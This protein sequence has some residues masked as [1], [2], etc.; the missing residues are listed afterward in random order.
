MVCR[1]P[2]GVSPFPV[3]ETD[4]EG[5]AL[6]WPLGRLDDLTRDDFRATA[7]E[8]FFTSC[9]SSPGFGGR[10]GTCDPH[11]N[12][13]GRSPASSHVAGGGGANMS[14]N[15]RIKKSL[16]LRTR[17]ATPMRVMSHL[18][19]PVMSVMSPAMGVAA[20]LLGLSSG[21]MRQR[22]MT[23]A[24]IMRQQMGITEQRD[25]CLRKTL[26]RAFVGQGGKKVETIIL[27]LELLRHLKPSD[28]NDAHE[29]HRWQRRQLKILE[30]GLL[31]HPSVPLDRMNSAAI[32]LADVIRSSSVKPIDTGKN[33]EAMRTLGNSVMALAWRSNGVPGVVCH[34]ADGYPL[35]VYLYLTLLRSVFDRKDE[36]VVLDE[37]DEL[38]ELMKKTWSTFGVNRT[39]HNVCF[40]WLLFEQYITTGQVEPD[41]ISATLAMLVEVAND[42]RR[43]HR[44]P[45]H[46]RV[47]SALLGTMQSWAEK[48]LLEYHAWYDKG[49]VGAMENVLGLALLTSQTLSEDASTNG[50]LGVFPQRTPSFR[51]KFSTV[52]S[53]ERYIRSSLKT[54]FTKVFENGNGK[55]DSMVVEV[56][57]NPN[58]TLVHLAKEVENLAVFEKENYSSIL[59]RWHPVPGVVALM[60]LHACYGIVLR[61]HLSRIEGL[62]NELVRVLHVAGKLEKLLVQMAVEESAE[63]EAEAKAILREMVPYE[64]DSVI[65]SLLRNWIDER[66]RMG[67][68]CVTRAKEIE[69][70]NPKSKTEP[71]AQSAVD[72][73][74]VAKVTVDEFFEIQVGGRD[75]VVQILTESLDSLIQDYTSFVASC[76]SK[77][78]YVPALPPLARCNQDSLVFFLWKKIATPC[79]AGI[80]PILFGCK[81]GVKPNVLHVRRGGGGHRAT[82]PGPTVSRGTQRLYVRLNT[83]HY[84]LGLL[85]SVDKSLSFFSRPG[86]SPSPRTPR[87][88]PLRRRTGGPTNF[89]LARSTIHGAIAHVA[90]VAAHR[91][92]FLDSASSFYNSIYVGNVSES[93]VRPTIRSLKQNLSLLVT[94][95]SDRAQPL[96]V[97]EIMNASFEAFLLVLLAGGPARA[98]YRSDYEMVIEDVANL[99]RI[100]CTCGEGLVTEEVV[101]KEAARVEGVVSLMSL[102]SEKLVEDLTFMACETIGLGRSMERLPM[103]PTTGRWSRTD[104]NTVLR[105]LCHRNDDVANRFL[106]R[107]FN[108]P[109]R[110]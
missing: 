50:I 28:F 34:W 48:R 19:S 39:V 68:E 43:Q 63:A 98:F 37:V 88:T 46:V 73:M 47:L 30:A 65:L 49:A 51:T 20:G 42:A 6:E 57:E 103:P 26:V 77:Q 69:S 72:L 31:L 3:E 102:P 90:E 86:P 10:S 70:W 84:L 81:S 71:Y 5:A 55:F 109:K 96:A 92:I 60:T 87:C 82:H 56:D 78:S 35:N 4:E 22:P 58:D 52:S 105:V 1:R 62:T 15:S 45:G 97:R 79:R 33:S 61:Q 7:Y 91:L 100:F 17:R 27:P 21:K 54:A 8:I 85:H 106:K 41:L 75:G 64:V 14:V 18:S 67:R 16:G 25:N 11:A 29:Y 53:V 80:D 38:L 2:S 66:L 83:L 24:E 76:G 108:L 32:R 89:D 12:Q 95:L 36:T 99:K 107:A 94:M 44:E 93:R 110:K 9:R 23:S 59:K 13:A 104:P 101:Q 40:T 74:K